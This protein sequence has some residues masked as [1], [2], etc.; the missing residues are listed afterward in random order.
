[1]GLLQAHAERQDV[2]REREMAVLLQR[3][4]AAERRARWERERRE[5]AEAE[6]SRV[7]RAYCREVVR[8]IAGQQQQQQQQQ[9]Q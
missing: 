3:V 4:D 8:S 9:Q 1:M 7:K 2:A 5:K 6:V